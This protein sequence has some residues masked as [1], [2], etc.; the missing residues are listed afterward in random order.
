MR[1]EPKQLVQHHFRRGIALELD[2]DAH[3]E[4]V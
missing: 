1:R 4:P 2:D 3:A